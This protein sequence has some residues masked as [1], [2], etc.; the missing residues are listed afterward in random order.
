MAEE[1]NK[2]ELH[3]EEILLTKN[4]IIKENVK[5]KKTRLNDNLTKEYLSKIT[6]YMSSSRI[7]LDPELTLKNFADK[8]GIASHHVSQV[9]N[10]ALNQNFF[11][12][13]NSYRIKD[14]QILLRDPEYKDYN[15]LRIAFE[16][17]F[18]SKP[19]FNAVFKNITQQTP[20]EYRNNNRS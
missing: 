3:R 20:S 13:V 10:S 1:L 5:Y 17:G 9:I 8:V 2:G 4:H 16:V 12:F 11:N 15:I 18:N 19:T 7:Y 14:A 6:D